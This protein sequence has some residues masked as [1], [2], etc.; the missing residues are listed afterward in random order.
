MVK[1]TVAGL[2]LLAAVTGCG[3]G[4][5]QAAIYDTGLGN[6]GS[7]DPHWSVVQIGGSFSAN[8]GLTDAPHAYIATDNNSFPFGYWAAPSQVPTGSFQPRGRNRQ[9]RSEL[10]AAIIFI[11]RLFRSRNRQPSPANSSPTTT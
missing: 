6:N 8:K 1:N 9:P 10:P 11:P 4:V 3:M 2:A 5:A 7:I